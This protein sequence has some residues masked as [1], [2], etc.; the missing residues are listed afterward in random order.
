MLVFPWFL[1]KYNDIP[2]HF[3]I[4]DENDP[5]LF[6][7]NFLNEFASWMND[8]IREANLSSICRPVDLGILQIVIR[9]LR[10]PTFYEKCRDFSL[11]HEL[12]HIAHYQK[13]KRIKLE[14]ESKKSIFEGGMVIGFFLLFL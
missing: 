11:A 9:L 14:D 1:F 8:K 2:Y 13:E 3:R 12:S 5:R 4:T 6:D 7:Q 10:D